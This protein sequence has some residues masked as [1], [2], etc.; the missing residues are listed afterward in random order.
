MNGFHHIVLFTFP[1]IQ[2]AQTGLKPF[3]EEH[4]ELR[5]WIYE[6]VRRITFYSCALRG[7]D[8]ENKQ[9]GMIHVNRYNYETQLL[10]YAIR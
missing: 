8:D 9:R 5:V 10:R 2:R 3:Y 7:A 4:L 6:W 1:I